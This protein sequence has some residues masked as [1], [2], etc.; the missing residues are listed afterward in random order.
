MAN[1][2]L[3]II[4]VKKFG[5]SGD[6]VTDDTTALKNAISYAVSVSGSLFI[7]NGIYSVSGGTGPGSSTLYISGATGVSIIGENAIIK[8]G[9]SSARVLLI[10]NSSRIRV[11]GLKIIG[12]TAVL[13]PST[14]NFAMLAISNGS[15]DVTVENCYFTNSLGDCVYIGGDI[16]NGATLGQQSKRITINN[17]TLKTRYGNGVASSSS[18][19]KSRFAL[20]V[21]DCD[22][23]TVTNNRIFGSFDN[24]PNANLQGIRGLIFSN[25]I[26]SSG[27]VRPQAVIGSNYNFDEAIVDNGGLYSPSSAPTVT[28]S[29]TGGSIPSGTYYAVVTYVN[30]YG[31]TSISPHSSAISCTGASTSVLTI[32]GGAIPGNATGVNIY[33]SYQTN[34][35][36]KE[37]FVTGYSAGTSAVVASLPSSGNS[38][39]PIEL[40][41]SVAFTGVPS[42]SDT[43]NNVVQGNIIE[44]GVLS[45]GNVYS[46]DFLDNR[47]VK[48]RII[49]GA[50]TGGGTSGIRVVGNKL[51]YLMS[52]V[53]TGI[54]V[55]NF[56]TCL[57]QNNEL[58]YA[59]GAYMFGI[60]TPAGR[61]T[62]MN[63]IFADNTGA[64]MF[65][66]TS[67]NANDISIGNIQ[68]TTVTQVA[69]SNVVQG[70]SLSSLPTASS[71]YRGGVA[72]LLGGAGVQDKIYVCKKLADETYDWVE[73]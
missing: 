18:G 57:F 27:P 10:G 44:N 60:L 66:G 43:S 56:N 17:C 11:E 21:T 9:P 42:I 63:N 33:L 5:A 70:A 48:G 8:Q 72:T 16:T 23:L 55:E 13:D 41:T 65:T 69:I 59:P 49:I 58:Y 61:S 64:G 73:I 28:V 53:L 54:T 29:P 35:P 36:G 25:N 2:N 3:P 12:Y 14:E 22:T 1:V 37:V 46:A 34:S 31:E 40:T 50:N 7:P 26:C 52:G 68:T 24:E 45:C 62:F 15:T 47:F 67:L 19:S 51:Q 71:S 30:A 6:G 32:T 20:A 38:W 4:D 39:P